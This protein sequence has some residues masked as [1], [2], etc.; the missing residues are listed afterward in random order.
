MSNKGDKEQSVVSSLGF[1]VSSSADMMAYLGLL[2]CG[3]FSL[4]YSDNEPEWE[5]LDDRIEE[6]DNILENF[7]YD[8]EVFKENYEELKEEY[9]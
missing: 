5:H 2:N 6:V 7:Q 8:W 3:G 4:I 9:E 1:A